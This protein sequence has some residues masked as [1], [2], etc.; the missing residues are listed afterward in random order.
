M[1]SAVHLRS[2]ERPSPIAHSIRPLAHVNPAQLIAVAWAPHPHRPRHRKA[3]TAERPTPHE[4]L[5]LPEISP[6]SQELDAPRTGPAPLPIN[7]PHGAPRSDPRRRAGN[8]LPH[9]TQLA[10]SHVSRETSVPAPMAGQCPRATCSTPKRRRPPLRISAPSS[11]LLHPTESDTHSGR[12]IA[13]SVDALLAPL[14][15]LSLLS[16]VARCLF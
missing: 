6:P 10:S 15:H 2:L 4:S 8:C 7:G 1:T 12:G 14:G 16:R 13:T 5:T 11:V 9:A 3:T